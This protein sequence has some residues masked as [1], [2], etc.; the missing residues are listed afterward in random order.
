MFSHN[1]A[2]IL[3]MIFS[4]LG[5]VSLTLVSVKLGGKLGLMTKLIAAGIFFSVFTHAGFELVSS[6][7]FI[8]EQSLLLIMG[9]LLT[10][11][12]LLFIIG[13]YVGFKSIR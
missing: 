3:A 9:G 4:F 13:G 11:G 2:N 1:L 8:D 6:L 5:I 10:F 12:S 7:G